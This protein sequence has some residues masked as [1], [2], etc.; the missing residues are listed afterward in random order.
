MPRLG[1]AA[2]ASWLALLGWEFA[3]HEERGD[4]ESFSAVAK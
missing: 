2:T 4:P 1:L 3:R